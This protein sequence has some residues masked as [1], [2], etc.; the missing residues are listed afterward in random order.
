MHVAWLL[1][2]NMNG[3]KDS[4][5]SFKMHLHMSVAHF[6]VMYAM[7]RFLLSFCT[8]KQD[9]KRLG[10]WWAMPIFSLHVMFAQQ[11]IVARCN[12]N[13]LDMCTQYAGYRIRIISLDCVTMSFKF[14]EAYF[15]TNCRSQPKKC[16]NRIPSLAS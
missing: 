11:R 4:R 3:N 9:P 14:R 12:V 15:H 10:A 13:T 8:M 1:E 6:A 2:D 7:Y 5:A 16:I